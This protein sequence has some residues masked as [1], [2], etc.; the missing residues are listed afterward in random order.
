M[1]DLDEDFVPNENTCD[2]CERCTMTLVEPIFRCSSGHEICGPCY[3]EVMLEKELLSGNLDLE[4]DDENCEISEEEYEDALGVE[5]D[6]SEEG[7][8]DRDIFECCKSIKSKDSLR[9]VQ[10]KQPG[11]MRPHTFEDSTDELKAMKLRPPEHKKSF[12]DMISRK[13][14]LNISYVSNSD[15]PEDQKSDYSEE[16]EENEILEEVFKKNS[17]SSLDSVRSGASLKYKPIVCPLNSCYKFVSVSGLITHFKF[18]H[19]QIPIQMT[20][21][22][23]PVSFF[24]QSSVIESKNIVNEKIFVID[25]DSHEDS[26][27]FALNITKQC[28]AETD[29]LLIWVSEIKLNSIQYLYKIQAKNNDNDRGKVVSYF[30]PVTNHQDPLAVFQNGDCLVIPMTVFDSFKDYADGFDV[31]ITFTVGPECAPVDAIGDRKRSGCRSG[32]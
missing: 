10:L 3:T 2:T 12:I 26:G 5:D 1:S 22:N 29:M 16:I 24:V 17:I 25:A 14:G 11:S 31:T 21:C 9:M 23:D 30:G 8:E 28:F 27:Y 20:A 4:S 32:F 15:D 7:N 6:D 18:D 19:P 13:S